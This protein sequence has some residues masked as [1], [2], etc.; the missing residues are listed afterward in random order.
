METSSACAI[1]S[2]GE[3]FAGFG[4]EFECG[5][6]WRMSREEGGGGGGVDGDKFSLVDLGL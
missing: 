5:I 1:S 4:V 3:E 6:G 2:G